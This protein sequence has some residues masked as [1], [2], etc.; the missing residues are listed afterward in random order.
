MHTSLQRFAEVLREWRVKQRRTIAE[1]AA[2][3]D[4]S[5]ATWGHWAS[6]LRF[7][8]AQNLI[9]LSNQTGVSIQH[10]FCPNAERCRFAAH[11]RKRKHST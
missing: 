4:V 3:L 2:E 8:S 5:V 1:V 9:K 10:F 11:N 6:G 7:P